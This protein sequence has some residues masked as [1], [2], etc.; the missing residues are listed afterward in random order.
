MEF[1]PWRYPATETTDLQQ[2]HRRRSLVPELN[3]GGWA[4]CA[5][6]GVLCDNG[7]YIGDGLAVEG[8]GVVVF[9]LL[10]G[11]FLFF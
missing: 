2:P 7:V 5:A 4:D 9:L 11:I 3:R 6:V 8:L 1:A 10:R